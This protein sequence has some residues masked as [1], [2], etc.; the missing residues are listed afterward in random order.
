MLLDRVG[1][2]VKVL[3]ASMFLLLTLIVIAESSHLS[4][5]KLDT[6]MSVVTEDLAPDSGIV[7]DITANMLNKQLIVSDYLKTGLE[8]NISDFNQLSEQTILILNQANE[9][10]E[11]PN[12][13]A[14]LENINALS[15]NYDQAFIGSVVSNMRERNRL[16]NEGMNVAGSQIRK[17]LTYIRESAYKDNDIVA[18]YYAGVVQENLLLARLYAFRFLDD[19]Q[20]SS[21]DRVLNELSAASRE[22]N[23]LMPELQNANRRAAAERVREGIRNHENAFK[24]VSSSIYDRNTVV[25]A[26]LVPFGAQIFDA[27][28][29][30]QSSVFDSL[31]NEGAMASAS[32]K[33]TQLTN[34]I[35]VI[36]SIVLGLTVS[37]WI[38]KTVV[39][40]VRRMNALVDD[41][42]KGE[43]DLTARLPEDSR[44]EIGA[45]S[46]SMNEF[47]R[48]L[49]DTIIAI[50]QQTVSV[51]ENSGMLAEH[52]ALMKQKIQ[53]Q[54]RET[55]QIATAMVEMTTTSEEVS[56]N[57][58]ETTNA[59]NSA[60]SEVARGVD[61]IRSNVS[62]I[63]QVAN[64][65]ETTSAS[66][67]Q[68]HQESN[69]IN[70]ILQVILDIAEQTNLLA[71]NAANEAARAGEQGRGFA[72][73]ADEVRTLAKR[74]QDS[75]SEIGSVLSTLQDSS[76]A[77]LD[78]MLACREL[79]QQTVTQ[80]NDTKT[81][82]DTIEQAI[83]QILNMAGQTATAS[84][85]QLSVSE[86]ISRN[87]TTTQALSEETANGS[88]LIAESGQNLIVAVDA[89]K[90]EIEC[91]KVA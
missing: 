45:M 42:A 54:A 40:K 24:A 91:F 38:A 73:V 77:S 6:Q 49:Q 61:T 75:T 90:N 68:L 81:S 7:A 11:D 86:E 16:V 33:D 34:Q 56:R 5:S 67:E 44:D 74:T 80:S 51:S 21:A 20:E 66:M 48:G 78:A 82:L 10:I 17:E 64:E 58:E 87:V 14:I 15:R 31:L 37:L 36:A 89:L 85:E 25:E 2:T 47:I 84:S 79:A 70:N 19:N 13:V 52:S 62:T 43:G 27:S 30:L 26:Q 35:I 28:V 72:V 50:G 29:N 63:E 69:N 23:T 39:G 76:K 60:E 59:V 8:Q 46:K 71:L 53:G 12:R 32:I 55:E 18:A 1:F 83:D 57:A 88:L 65:I 3:L 22:L 9:R 4:K 41:L